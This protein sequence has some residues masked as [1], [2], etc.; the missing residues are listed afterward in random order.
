V[1]FI[2]GDQVLDVGRREL[3]RRGELIA[4]EPQV[5][6]LLVYLVRNRDRVVSKDDLLEAIWGGRIVSESTLS[7]RI[8]AVRRG[9][10]DSGEAQR[11]IRTIPRKGIRF[12]AVVQEERAAPV[13]ARSMIAPDFQDLPAAPSTEVKSARRLS[14][15]VLPFNNLSDD[16]EQQYFAD[17]ITDDLT[18]D[19]SR[20][21]GSFV[22]SR[23]TA[24]TY[25]D[26]PV[27]AK[28]IGRELGVRYVL[29]GSVR[30]SGK[31][32]RVNAQ[33]IDATTDAHL[34]AER[35]GGATGDLFALQDEIT[36][37]IAVTLH[38]EL[39][40]AEAARLTEH[41]DA[42]DYVFRGRAAGSKPPTR[43]N[44][45]EAISLFERAL[46]LDPHSVEAQSWLANTLAGR[47]MNDMTD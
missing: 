9:V 27:S 43:D 44:Y 30:R 14:I 19:L 4:L 11:L 8:N 39:V 16:R 12:V 40:G 10:G 34:W 45:V 17:A 20:I 15:V 47:V 22:I 41:P 28:Q 26:K 24:F 35:F 3:R 13:D 38:L 33:L 32:V 21:S 2:F 25:K 6:D 46:A 1:Q 18:T 23:N 5:F 7:S 29:E 37:R 36:R 42:L 31:Q